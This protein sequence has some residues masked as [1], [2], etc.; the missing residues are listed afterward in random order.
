MPGSRYSFVYVGNFRMRPQTWGVPQPSGYGIGICRFDNETGALTPLRIVHDH[1]TAGNVAFDAK[2]QVIYYGHEDLTL[3]DRVY[4]GGG[5]VFAFSVDVETGDLTEINHQP[6]YGALPVQVA[7]DA[8]GQY[9][10]VPHH[11]GSFPI[12]KVKKDAAGRYC[13]VSEYDDASIALFPLDADGAIGDPCDIYIHTGDGGPLEKQ[14]HP[15]L[16]TVVMSPSGK[17]FFVSDKGND[18]ILMFRINYETRKLELCGGKPFATV[19]GASVRCAAFHPTR[20]WL[21]TNYE[22]TAA[23]AT[24]RYDE[25]GALAP[26]S[27]ASALP[28]GLA[29][30]PTLMQSDIKIHPSGRHLFTLVR[31]INSVTAFAIDEATGQLVRIQTFQL[32]GKNPRSCTI[33]PDG[34]FLLVAMVLS[35]EVLV[36]AIGADGTLTSTG[37]KASMP[38]PANIAFLQ[39]Q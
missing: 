11:T 17:L 19:P 20:P 36:L 24:L 21:F 18:Q 12:T 30:G 1:I 39:P 37:H 3:P 13:T 16:H 35:A 25:S 23:V 2:R 9:L 6:S 15:H 34:R 28:E 29:D 8:T 22:T 5:Q 10:I 38:H 4:G 31:G 26:L 27:V 33:S 14:T 32:E 7:L